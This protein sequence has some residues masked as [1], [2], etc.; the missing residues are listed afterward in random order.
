MAGTDPY[1]TVSLPP[2]LVLVREETFMLRPRQVTSG[3]R[4]SRGVRVGGA[5]QQVWT[6]DLDIDVME[7]PEWQRWKAFIASLDGQAVLFELIVPSQRLPLGAG[8]GFAPTNASHEVT[9]TTI[10]G[11]RIVTGGTTALITRNAA[12]YAAA[13]HMR[14]PVGLAGE[15]VL[16]PGDVFSLGGNLY[17]VQGR[18]RPDAAGEAHVPFR[19]KLWRGARVG[20]V[21]RFRDP[22]CRMQLTGPDIGEVLLRSPLLGRSGLQ[23]EEV[24]Y[25]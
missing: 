17:M 16:E 4:L 8:A 2:Q 5:R 22:T 24:P 14:F 23:A 10:T 13:V 12:R 1:R 25:V 15:V 3:F 11:T 19:W 7:R 6:C 18:V 20:D 9:G 21:V